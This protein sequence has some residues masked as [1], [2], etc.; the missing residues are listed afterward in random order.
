MLFF[1]HILRV[2]FVICCKLCSKKVDIQFKIFFRD[3]P[4][5]G[6]R[7]PDSGNAHPGRGDEAALAVATSCMSARALERTHGLASHPATV[8]MVVI[9][10]V[11]AHVRNANLEGFRSQRIRRSLVQWV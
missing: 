10:G 2:N 1:T 5:S 11:A 3:S 9:E 6:I 7:N 8:A 4:N